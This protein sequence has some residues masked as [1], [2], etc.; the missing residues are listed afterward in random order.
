MWLDKLQACKLRCTQLSSRAQLKSSEAQKLARVRDSEAREAQKLRRLRDSLCHVGCV[1]PP[2]RRQ[3]S[4]AWAASLA[5]CCVYGAGGLVR[6]R[7]AAACWAQL[8]GVNR[9]DPVGGQGSG[10]AA[11][12][13][14]VVQHQ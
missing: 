4:E 5:G 1:G 13:E 7:A 3:L 14:A 10:C 8:G 2:S 9:V 11:A 6:W 12:A